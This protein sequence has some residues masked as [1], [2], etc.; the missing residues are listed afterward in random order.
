MLVWVRLTDE[1]YSVEM[2]SDYRMM[3]NMDSFG[4]GRCL[5]FDCWTKAIAVEGVQPGETVTPVLTP[6]TIKNFGKVKVCTDQELYDYFFKDY[7]NAEDWWDD[8]EAIGFEYN[9]IEYEV[10][11]R[12]WPDGVQEDR[13]WILFE[14]RIGASEWGG[15]KT[16]KLG[17]KE[18][19]EVHEI[20]LTP[21]LTT[22]FYSWFTPKNF[23]NRVE[24]TRGSYREWVDEF[25]DDDDDDEWDD[26]FDF[27]LYLYGGDNPSHTFWVDTDE[28]P[29]LIKV[30]YAGRLVIRSGDD[31]IDDDYTFEGK[32]SKWISPNADRH[33]FSTIQFYPAGAQSVGISA[34]MAEL[35]ETGLSE[36]GAVLY[37]VVTGT[38]TF[39]AGERV[40][41]KAVSGGSK[42][43]KWEVVSGELPDGV[44]LT[45]Q[46]LS[47]TVPES[48]CGTPEEAKQVVVRARWAK[49]FTLSLNASPMEGGTVTGSG[50]YFSGD[51]VTLKATPKKGFIFAGWYADEAFETPLV[52]ASDYRAQS[53]AY[54]MPERGVDVTARFVKAEE[55]SSIAFR[56]KGIEVETDP[57]ASV[58]YVADGLPLD[59]DVQSTSVPKVSVSGL[60]SGLKFTAKQLLN[61][62]KSVLA[63]ANSIYGTATKPGRYVVTVKLTNGTVKK[64][65]EKKF[66]L[67]VDN[68]TAANDDFQETPANARGERYDL[69]VGVS[70]LSGMPNLALKSS[71]AKLSVSGLPSGLKYNAKT[72]TIA[73]VPMKAGSFTVYLTVSEGRT[74]RISTLTLDVAALPNW[75][76]GS[77]EGFGEYEDCCSSQEDDA[78]A[79]MG[80]LAVSSAGKLSGKLT[81]DIGAGRSNPSGS[82]SLAAFDRVE[83]APDDGSSCYYATITTTFTIQRKKITV[84][85]ELKFSSQTVGEGL[86]GH[87]EVYGSQE[88]D[89]F[90]SLDLNQN[91]FARKDFI[92][93]LKSTITLSATYE[94]NQ[95]ITAKISP[96]GAVDLI[97]GEGK[98]SIKAKGKLMLTG[99]DSETATYQADTTF[100]LSDGRVGTVGFLLKTDAQG[101][102]VQE[103]SVIAGDEPESELQ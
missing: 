52:G 103:G 44:D 66:T 47:F 40:S 58:F 19:G 54:T 55:D 9:G 99:Y 30:P 1:F 45:K 38:G 90:I 8:E 16:F 35:D 17:I 68:L 97:L 60:P 93:P 33:E 22:E 42:F 2:S 75:L 24:L 31:Y 83:R 76:V 23:F 92:S 13:V 59:L 41:L 71:S 25:G 61:K 51:K 12:I 53:I 84:S 94:E 56:V 102:I 98:G 10:D 64:P 5:M 26:Y 7:E 86:A 89:Y 18:T 43:Y 78:G 67:V 80:T 46:T 28:Q 6:G 65:I 32:G 81:L 3:W 100:R 73:G 70:D 34:A 37:G 63:E 15:L 36:S 95:S 62:D 11:R 79:I 29:F 48:M 72:G 27:G 69:S 74:K 4:W 96:K 85:R 14:P 50:A 82:F 21:V 39:K 101:N 91:L 87:A 49:R 88:D 77:Y 57:S 20:G